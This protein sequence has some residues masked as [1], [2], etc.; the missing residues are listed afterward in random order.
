MHILCGLQKNRNVLDNN[1]HVSAVI[2]Y[3]L[4]VRDDIEVDPVVL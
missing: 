3:Q 4:S 1:W 2:H